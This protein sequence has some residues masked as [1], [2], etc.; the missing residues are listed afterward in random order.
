MVD[1]A[2]DQDERGFEELVG[3]LEEVVTTLERGG[4]SLEASLELFEEGVRLSRQASGRLEGA[5]RRIEELL[6]DGRELPLDA[7]PTE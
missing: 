1:E 7:E 6:S 5:E 4:L 2:T 3:R